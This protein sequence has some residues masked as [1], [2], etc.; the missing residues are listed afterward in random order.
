MART[1]RQRLRPFQANA[2]GGLGIEVAAADVRQ[3]FLVPW[4]AANLQK[5]QA[6]GGLAIYCQS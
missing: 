3:D 6:L 2:A 1:A 5:P 4:R